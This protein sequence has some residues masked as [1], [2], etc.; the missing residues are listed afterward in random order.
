MP[1]TP[2]LL[3]VYVMHVQEGVGGIIWNTCTNKDPHLEMHIGNIGSGLMIGQPRSGSI[4]K[5]LSLISLT[6][7][8]IP[9]RIVETGVYV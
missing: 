2:K 9:H 1:R 8:G 7:G 5:I 3:V 6:Y 4:S